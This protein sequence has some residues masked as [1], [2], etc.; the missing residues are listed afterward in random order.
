MLGFFLLTKHHSNIV[1]VG[2][3][4]WCGIFYK[5]KIIQSKKFILRKF[6]RINKNQLRI[7]SKSQ[8]IYSSNKIKI[9]CTY[10]NTTTKI[11]KEKYK[12]YKT[13]ET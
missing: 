6:I 13:S 1:T 10:N 3:S 9:K 11:L 5:S 8:V 2:E 12:I 7:A 4:R